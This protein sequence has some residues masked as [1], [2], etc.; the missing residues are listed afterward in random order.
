[1]KRMFIAA[2]IVGAFAGPAAAVEPTLVTFDTGR[3]GWQGPQGGGGHSWIA[4]RLGNDRPAY[5][6][7]F[8]DFGITFANSSNPAFVG[9]YTALPALEIGLDVLTRSILFS[10]SEVTRDLIVEL[11]D[12]DNAPDGY[13]YVSVWFKLGTLDAGADGWQSWSVTIAD[14][15]ATALPAG[16]GGYGAENPVTF[17]PELPDGRSFASVLAGVDE[18][19][20]TTLVPGFFY[21]DARF[22]VAID[23]VF[24]RAATPVPE[25]ATAA[26]LALGLAALAV[27]RRRAAAAR[28]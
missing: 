8:D 4:P 11:R 15:S 22:D 18:I 19:A 23:N 21:G 28:S 24:L 16:W 27:R 13:P 20:F 25:P 5:R 7:R 10:G 2:T 26:L 6:T 1:M 9:D 3:E 17:E 14:T 12:Y